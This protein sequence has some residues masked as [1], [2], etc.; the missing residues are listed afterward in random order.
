MRENYIK[1]LNNNIV[2]KNGLNLI[3][4]DI[5]NEHISICFVDAKNWRNNYCLLDKSTIFYYVI[6]GEG[7]FKINDNLYMLEILEKKLDMKEIHEF[8]E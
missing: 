6:E 3:L 1:N 8:N 4:P 2:S 5:E 7:S